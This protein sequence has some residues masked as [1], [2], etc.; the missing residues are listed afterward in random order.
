MHS[1]HVAHLDI[2]LQNLVTDSKG[3]YACIDYE[4]SRRFSPTIQS[5]WVYNYRGTEMPPECEGQTCV[6]PFKV[7]IWSL[8]VLILR[9]SKVRQT[10]NMQRRSYAYLLGPVDRTL[11]SGTHGHHFAYA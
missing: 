7:D 9:A 8:G 4:N 3:H 2:S 10:K 6:N 5:H 1:H 11:D